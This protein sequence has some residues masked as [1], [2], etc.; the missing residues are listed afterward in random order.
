MNT[1]QETLTL[2]EVSEK[3][4]IRVPFLENMVSKGALVVNDEGKVDIYE[5]EDF[6]ER[7]ERA[8]ADIQRAFA[9]QHQTSRELLSRVSGVDLETME[10]L[11][12]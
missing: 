3:T 2:E 5:Y 6:L 1:T 8:K 4:G 7:H 12:F 10:R 9:N 11:G